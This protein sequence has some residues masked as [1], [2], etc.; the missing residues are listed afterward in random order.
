MAKNEGALDPVAA[1]NVV[2]LVGRVSAAPERRQLPSGDELVT[3]RLIVPRP[4]PAKGG[5]AEE[6]TRVD[7][8]DIAC[9]SARTRR[10]A[11]R[12]DADLAVRVEGSLRR[13][14]FRSS[15]GAASRYEVEAG[16]VTRVRK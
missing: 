7:V 8:V 2:S 16:S 6:R 12:L 9:W 5:G 10:S 1:V 15:G 13:R 4:P 11:T 3:F 14:F